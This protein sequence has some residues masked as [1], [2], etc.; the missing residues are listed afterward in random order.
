MFA[1]LK[2]IP[3]M[4][5]NTPIIQIDC[6]YNNNEKHIFAKCEWFSL[7]GSIKDKVA[8]QIFIDAYKKK[9]L[10]RDDKIV[11]VSSGNM[12]ISICAMGNLF[13]NKVTI[14]MPK[15]MSDERKQLIKMYGA[16]L[17]ETDSFAQ[18]FKLCAEY[19][20][21]G[22]FCSKQFENISN[23][24]AHSKFT[25]KEIMHKLKKENIS[26]FVAG[27]GTSG[28][29]CGVGKILKQKAIK[30]VAIEPY[31]ARILSGKKPYKQHKS[32][33]LSDE[34][35]PKLYDSVKIDEILQIKD[36]DAI[37]MSQRLVSELSLGV[38]ISSGAN[39]LGS[40]LTNGN[41]VTVFPDDNKKYLSTDLS[42]TCNSHL[43]DSIQFTGIKFL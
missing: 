19:V 38:G 30:I 33:G 2:T 35:V 21:N 39:F 11:E 3:K 6:V 32:Q 42:K 1:D 8:Y 17:I 18:A 7:T 23:L 16:E 13:G 27:V 25:A 28:T 36:D 20:K 31:N 15:S 4:F 37:R 22:Y 24:K 34:I 5:K 29:L 43:A 41:A 9:L 14:I 10:K 40:V 12:G 26:S